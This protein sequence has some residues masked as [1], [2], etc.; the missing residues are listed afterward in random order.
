MDERDALGNVVTD[1]LFCLVLNAEAREVRY[2]LPAA[3]SRLV[4]EVALD[5]SPDVG[6]GI[7]D[8]RSTRR[9]DASRWMSP[10]GPSSCSTR[11]GRRSRLER[12]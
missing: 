1:D 12:I 3:V 6:A 5:T 4:W 10:R 11:A 2:V 8:W 9:T 7:G